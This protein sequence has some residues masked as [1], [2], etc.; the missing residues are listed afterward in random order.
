M[1]TLRRE[2]NKKRRTCYQK[3]GTAI[4]NMVVPPFFYLNKKKGEKDMN[5]VFLIGRL[6]ADPEVRYTQSA[7]PVANFRIAV[8]RVR[9]QEGGPDADFFPIVAWGRLAEVVRDYCGKGRQVAVIGRLQNRSWEGQ[10]GKSY[11]VTEVIAEEL[12]L[13]AQPTGQQETTQTTAPMQQ[14]TIE[15]FTEIDAEFPFDIDEQD[16]PF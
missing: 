15:G 7:T 4:N 6:T 1:N 12:E 10:D 11:Y 2:G 8:R 3:G 14:D 9:K 5:K 16:L 13:L